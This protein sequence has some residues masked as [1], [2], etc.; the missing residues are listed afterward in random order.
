MTTEDH[1]RLIRDA[2]RTAL[3]P[4]GFQQKGRS[5]LWLA[6]RGF[7]AFM[8][9]FQPSGFSKG[10]YL[11]IGATW[12]WHPRGGHIFN[13][14]RR[15]G[16]FISFETAA[17]FKPEA[18]RLAHVAAAEA[19]A[20]DRKFESLG[21]IA[22]DLR[23]EANDELSGKNPWT[24]YHAAIAAGLTDGQEF[25]LKCFQELIDQTADVDW[26]REIQAEAATLMRLLAEGRGF[27]AAIRKKVAHTRAVL[28]FPALGDTH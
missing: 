12:L 20:L 2:A 25:S 24:L 26:K 15:A 4:L 28:K 22:R 18:E 7:W 19:T 17:Q 9:E 1:S 6:D 10:S 27:D 8:I 13:S 14:F 5:R 23:E 16:D 21:A 11:N 3:S